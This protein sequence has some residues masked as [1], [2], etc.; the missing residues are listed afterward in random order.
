[1]YIKHKYFFFPEEY[2]YIYIYIYIYVYI[3]IYIYMYTYIYIHA[4]YILNII[5][6]GSTKLKFVWK[7]K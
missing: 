3:Y 7:K 1:M 5:F 4:E 6:L 2:I